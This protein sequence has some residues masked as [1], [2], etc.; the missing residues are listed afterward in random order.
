MSTLSWVRHRLVQG[1]TLNADRIILRDVIVYNSNRYDLDTERH[2]ISVNGQVIKTYSVRGYNE[3]GYTNVNQD[4]LL[5]RQSSTVSA[6]P[7]DEP[8][9][10]GL[11]SGSR[12][13]AGLRRLIYEHHSG[14]YQRPSFQYN[15]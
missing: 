14:E 15:R 6:I 13:H 5:D 8:V 7:T 1:I 4:I 10:D 11:Q 2:N 9:L 3:D 12:R